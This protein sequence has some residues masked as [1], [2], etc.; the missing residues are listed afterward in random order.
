M[1]AVTLTIDLEDPT[2]EYAKDGRW[3]RMAYRLIDFCDEVQR[4]ATIFTVGR[5]AEASPTLIQELA[6]RG[7]EIAYHTHDHVFLTDEAPERFRRE[8]REDKDKL[9]QLC[10]KKVAGFRAPGFSLTHQT[11]WALDIIKE[12]GFVYSSSIMPTNISRFGMPDKPRT[13]FKWPNGLIEFPLPVASLGPLRI[14]YSGGI[15]LYA[16]PSWLSRYWASKADPKECLWTYTH[17]FDFDVEAPFQ[18]HPR[19]PLWISWVMWM[20]RKQAKKKVRNIL[21]IGQA[22]TL[23]ELCTEQDVI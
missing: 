15:Y 20:L 22:P 6:L 18:P 2:G 14:P 11:S 12:L 23:G 19:D 5:V 1:T 21:S 7:H 9:E 13:P 4:K 10:G 17:P 8:S 16:L 3:V